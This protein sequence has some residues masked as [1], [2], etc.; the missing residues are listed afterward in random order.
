MGK[1]EGLSNILKKDLFFFKEKEA[2]PMRDN[3]NEPEREEGNQKNL[4]LCNPKGESF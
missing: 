4:T 3:M 2:M 1:E